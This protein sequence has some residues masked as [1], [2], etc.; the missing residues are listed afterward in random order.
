MKDLY[1]IIRRPLQTEKTQ[2]GLE[3]RQYAFEVAMAA[4]K[5]DVREAVQQIFGVHVEHV[6]TCI[7]RGK[8]KRFGRKI[9]K[10]PNWKKAVVRI[11]EGQE[12]ESLNVS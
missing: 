2:I 4:T 6:T 12:I 9:G 8:K 10:R 11:G 7:M 5:S 3:N 1:A